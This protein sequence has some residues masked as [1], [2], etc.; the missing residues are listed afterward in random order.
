MC[1]CNNIFILSNGATV[2]FEHIPATPMK[3]L[4]LIIKF[5]II[6]KNI[7]IRYNKYNKYVTIYV[8]IF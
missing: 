8:I 5:L 7:N 4:L 1:A 3:F 2:V 6:I